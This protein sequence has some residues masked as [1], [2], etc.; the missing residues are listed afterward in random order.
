MSLKGITARGF[1]FQRAGEVKGMASSSV[2]WGRAQTLRW[3][4]LLI[5]LL[6]AQEPVTRNSFPVRTGSAQKAQVIPLDSGI[7]SSLS[8]L[9][10]TPNTDKLGHQ[11]VIF[12]NLKKELKNTNMAE[13]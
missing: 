11:K 3:S 1:I 6:A 10:P 13:C 12:L 8:Q 5:G 7:F 2:T 9:Y 4:V